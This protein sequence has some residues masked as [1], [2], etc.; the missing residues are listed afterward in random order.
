MHHILNIYIIDLKNDVI[1]PENKKMDDQRSF[2]FTKGI[3]PSKRNYRISED[4]IFA[5]KFSI[6]SKDGN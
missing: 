1:N 2:F 6:S 4:K 3:K 5:V